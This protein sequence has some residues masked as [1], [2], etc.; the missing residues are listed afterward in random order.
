MNDFSKKA[1]EV[2]EFL[3]NLGIDFYAVSHSPAFTIE[4]CKEIEKLIGGE[5]C[6]NLF[7]QTS[8]GKSKFLLMLKGDKKFVTKDISKKLNSSRLSFGSEDAM[9]Q[10]LNT[11][12]GSLSITSLIFDKDKAVM[13]AID[14]DVLENEY[15]CCHPSDNSAT[16]KIKTDDILNKFIPALNITAQII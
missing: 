4:E 1:S 15:I 11:E 7:L 2:C 14:K 10:I 8:S 12:P 9:R 6:K 16:L 5:I 13:L 3:K